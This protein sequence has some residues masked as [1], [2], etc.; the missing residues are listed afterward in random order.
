[1]RGKK[2]ITSSSKRTVRF[3]GK[4]TSH[5]ETKKRKK[6]KNTKRIIPRGGGGGQKR[7]TRGGKKNKAQLEK[8]KEKDLKLV[9]QKK[10][11]KLN[12]NQARHS[13]NVHKVGELEGGGKEKEEP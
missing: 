10:P 3:E 6:A 13:I 9:V 2:N 4:N 5:P 1:L 11:K 7:E 8:K 12:K